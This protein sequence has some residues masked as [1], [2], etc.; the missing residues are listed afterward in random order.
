MKFF[1]RRLIIQNTGTKKV[2]LVHM[3]LEFQYKLSCLYVCLRKRQILVH[4]VLLCK[5]LHLTVICTCN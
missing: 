5:G 3:F 1:G 4:A 2:C